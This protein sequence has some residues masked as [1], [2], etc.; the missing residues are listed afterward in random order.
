MEMGAHA[1]Y[2]AGARGEARMFGGGLDFLRGLG[3][4]G[5]SDALR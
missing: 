1:V 5:E 3:F 2:I 4:G